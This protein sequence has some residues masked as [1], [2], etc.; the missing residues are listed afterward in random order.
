[1]S[2]DEDDVIMRESKTCKIQRFHIKC[3]RIKR[4]PKGKW[5]SVKCKRKKKTIEAIKNS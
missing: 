3:M 1:M 5:F 4:N 2:E